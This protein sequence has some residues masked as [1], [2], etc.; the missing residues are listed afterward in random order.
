[1]NISDLLP[2]IPTDDSSSSGSTTA[3]Q[4]LDRQ[5]KQQQLDQLTDLQQLL[6][7]QIS[8]D[9]EPVQPWNI[10]HRDHKIMESF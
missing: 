4:Q 9:A 1:V 10:R 8:K 7:E 3:G 6:T 2:K 5:P